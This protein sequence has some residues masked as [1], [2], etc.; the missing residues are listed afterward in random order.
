MPRCYTYT[1]HIG[2]RHFSNGGSLPTGTSLATRVRQF[3][4]KRPSTVGVSG[5]VSPQISQ[6]GLQ[7]NHFIVV[8]LFISFWEQQKKLFG[9][10]CASHGDLFPCFCPQL[11]TN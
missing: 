11:R 10:Q 6:Q 1:P 5:F 9:F 7:F 2:A 3:E 4:Q 8:M